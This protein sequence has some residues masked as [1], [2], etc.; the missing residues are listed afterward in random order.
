[1]NALEIAVLKDRILQH[2]NKNIGLYTDL[3][4]IKKDLKIYHIPE[5]VLKSY[6]KE[7]CDENVMLNL[8]DNVDLLSITDIG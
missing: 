6:I 8:F 1:M 3:D 2:L 5:V 4:I 7:M